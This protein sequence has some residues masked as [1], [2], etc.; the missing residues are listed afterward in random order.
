MFHAIL[1][2]L[3]DTLL[4]DS[5]EKFTPYYLE[6]LG[7]HFDHLVGKSL[8]LQGVSAGV[9]AMLVNEKTAVSN[10][11][12]FWHAMAEEIGHDSAALKAESLNFYRD[13]FPQLESHTKRNPTTRKLM[14][15]C[16]ARGWKVAIAT[17]PIY[18]RPAIE[19]RL[20]WA[21]VAVTAFAYARVTTYENSTAVKPNP[22]Y[23][24]QILQKIGSIPADTLMVGNDW[25]HDIVPTVA[26]GLSAY[27]IND[28]QI[29]PPDPDLVVGCGT[30]DMFFEYI[31]RV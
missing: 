5:S 18:P 21:G 29:D 16:F 8:F 28:G 13:V 12:V 11:D 14:Q 4:G 31:Q 2:D 26:L 17:N 1:F 23:Y 7:A 30:L 27:W 19:E 25:E 22:F 15:Y 9:E 10:A 3:D 24:Q 6:A 20:R